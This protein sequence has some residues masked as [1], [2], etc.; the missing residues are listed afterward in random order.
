MNTADRVSLINWSRKNGRTF[1]AR[2]W[3]KAWC[4]RAREEKR[5]AASQMGNHGTRDSIMLMPGD[6]TNPAFCS[7]LRKMGVIA[8]NFLIARRIFCARRT[9]RTMF[10]YNLVASRQRFVAILSALGFLVFV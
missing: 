3:I 9:A 1:P 8:A 4:A 7:R 2:Y 10:R 5:V 6:T